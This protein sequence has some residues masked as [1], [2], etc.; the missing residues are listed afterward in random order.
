MGWLTIMQDTST[1]TPDQHLAAKA[2]VS[3]YKT[4]L[5]SLIR[6]ADL[7]HISE[8]PDGIHWDAIQYFDPR[9]GH[10][11]VYVFRGSTEDEPTH[12]FV[13]KGLKPESKY[14]LTFHDHSAADRV[15]IGRELLKNGLS[16]SL[17]MPYSSELIFLEDTGR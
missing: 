2:E 3:L 15:S 1:W 6:D 5:R 10:G 11:V 13:L 14:R 8:R 7:Y 4:Q 9:A 17:G 12:T 16:V